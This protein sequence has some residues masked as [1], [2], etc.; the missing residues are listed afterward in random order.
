MLGSR[1]SVGSLPSWQCRGS[2]RSQRPALV[3]H[4]QRN[5]STA[6]YISP[7]P[8]IL[9]RDLQRE[10]S[11][12]QQLQGA[13]ASSAAA[14]DDTSAAA[15]RTADWVSHSAHRERDAQSE[16]AAGSAAAATAAATASP[17]VEAL[18]MRLAR[19]DALLPQYQRLAGQLFEALRVTAL[20]EVMPALTAL[21][22]T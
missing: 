13:G 14:A 6:L 16:K 21:T 7:P 22:A 3:A 4:L 9:C 1:A 18:R 8:P 10:R 11:V 5:E 2:H 12:A 19:L 15:A 20:D 17:E